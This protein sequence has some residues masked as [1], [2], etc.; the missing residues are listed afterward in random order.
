MLGVFAK[1]PGSATVK[2]R[3]QPRLTRAEAER[4][5]LASLADTLE[6]AARIERNPVLFLLDAETA[7]AATCSQRLDSI[8]TCGSVCRCRASVAMI[9]G[10]ASRRRSRRCAERRNA[11]S[12]HRVGQSELAARDAA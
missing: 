2:S 1:L 9:L 3:L 8:P 11:E 12:H 6:T 4:F 7:R 10:N 5:Y